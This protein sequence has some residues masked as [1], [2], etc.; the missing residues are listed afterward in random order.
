MYSP[1]HVHHNMYIIVYQTLS[2]PLYLF[3][4][5]YSPS[6]IHHYAYAVAYL[7]L[8]I[9][10]YVLTVRSLPFCISMLHIHR[11][12]PIVISVTHLLFCTYCDISAKSLSLHHQIMYPTSFTASYSLLHVSCLEPPI[13]Y[14][15]L[16]IHCCIFPTHMPC[17][18]YPTPTFIMSTSIFSIS[19]SPLYILSPRISHF[20]FSTVYSP[21]QS[22]S[23][24]C[25]ISVITFTSLPYHQSLLP[26]ATI[27]MLYKECC[28]VT[29]P[30]YT[31]TTAI[32]SYLII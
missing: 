8:Y 29:L 31:C 22:P 23:L 24:H 7:P 2:V 5:Q 27:A 12:I 18:V 20:V 4:I 9:N 3:T 25:Q 16:L 30:P 15:P 17:F 19:C 26:H 32:H 13:L 10:L 6:Y 1:S 14:S 21:L 28:I 11:S